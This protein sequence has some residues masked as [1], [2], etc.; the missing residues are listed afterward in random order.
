[1]DEVGPDAPLLAAQRADLLT[2]LPGDILTK[3]D[4][5]SMAHSL[6]VRPPLL[7]HDV[8]AFGLSLPAPLKLR[9]GTGKRVLRDVAAGLLPPE[10]LAAPKQG[11]A[12]GIGPALRLGHATVRAR[13]TGDAMGDS[14]LFDLP[15]LARL[16]DKHASGRNDH[17]QALWQ[18]LVF[19]GFLRG[20][21]GADGVS[22]TARPS[23]VGV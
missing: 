2:Y 5:A 8:V 20:E 21:A 18:L 11:F 6:E 15:A 9:N 3:V 17:S 23:L 12:D 13:L 19:E 10:V 4:R 22:A 14:G 1:M 16:A 7:D